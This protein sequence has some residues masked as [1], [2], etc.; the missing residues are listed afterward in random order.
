MQGR[1]DANSQ[2]LLLPAVLLCSVLYH[3][4]L[5]MALGVFSGRNWGRTLT[6]VY[7]LLGIAAVGLSL[8]RGLFPGIPLFVL[9]CPAPAWLAWKVYAKRCARLVSKFGQCARN[10]A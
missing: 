10:A 6:I 8:P 3:Y 9:A 7:C 4:L 2:I 1:G 5:Y